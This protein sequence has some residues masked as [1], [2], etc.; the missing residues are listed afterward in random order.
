[1]PRVALVQMACG[2]ESEANVQRALDYVKMAAGEGANI[3]ALQEVFPH[4]FFPQHMDKKF[5]ALAEPVPGP[6]I[7]RVRR[8][9]REHG[10]VVMA[11]IF[12]REVEGVYYNT[13]VLIDER[14]E[15]LGKYR[16]HHIPFSDHFMEKFYFK[17][18][19]LGFPVFQTSFGRIGMYI[20][21][22]RHFPE[23]AR[24]L[25]LRG[26]QIVLIPVASSRPVAREAYEIELRA[27]AI[28]NQYFVCAVNRV[29]RED[30][31]LYFGNSLVVDPQGRILAQANGERDELLL[32]DL[33]LDR[34]AEVRDHWLFYRDRRPEAYGPLAEPD[35]GRA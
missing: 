3:V 6:T 17:P 11:P 12:E 23:G 5:F 18:G 29:G 16:K 27:L 25:G 15:I 9:A 13:A 14:G 32:A 34:L 22:D 19:N 35:P 4:R 30:D 7:D 10:V 2:E 8:A 20:C 1:M 26:A 21:Y 28:A 31:S 24:I 33:D